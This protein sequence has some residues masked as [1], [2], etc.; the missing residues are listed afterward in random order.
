M[1]PKLPIDSNKRLGVFH[2]ASLLKAS[3]V[4]IVAMI[5]WLGI[6]SWYEQRLIKDTRQQITS[7][8]I[9][10]GN[11]LTTALNERLAL[12]SGLEA[13]VQTTMADNEGLRTD[14]TTFASGLQSGTKGIRAIQLFPPQGPV[15]VY[16]VRSN[17][18]T[19]SRTLQ[20]LINDERPEVRTDVKKAMATRRISLSGPYQLRQ[21]GLG[22]VARL[23]VYQRETFWGMAVIVFDVP[24]ILQLAGMIPP[25]GDLDLGLRDE[26]KRVFAGA[27]GVFH[28]DPV[29]YE[30]TLPGRTWEL[31]AIA[32]Q[33]WRHAY[34]PGLRFFQIAGL[35]IVILLT[36]L[37]YALSNQQ[38]RLRYLVTLRTRALRESEE[39]FRAIFEQAPFGVALMDSQTGHFRLVNQ[40]FADIVG[41]SREE[42]TSLDRTAITAPDDLQALQKK[43]AL[44]SHDEE[45]GF[46]M[47]K[48]LIRPD[49]SHV[50]VDMTIARITVSDTA[51]ARHLTM[52]QDISERKRTEA[53]QEHLRAQLAQAQKMESVG[54]LAGGVA[55]D[56]NNMLGII[57]GHADLKLSTMEPNHPLFSTLHSIRD[58]AQRS[59]NLVR[60]LL[61]FA[62]KQTIMPKILD[63]NI[64]VESM[65]NML[66]R[67]IS[68]DTELVWL[69]GAA[70]WKVRM[71]PI[72]IDQI[73]ANLIV[74]ARDAIDGMG[75]ITIETSNASLDEPL[76]AKNTGAVCGDYV[77]LSVRDNGS[78]MDKQTQE[79]LF[80]PFFTTKET[81]KGTGLGMATVYG[82]VTQNKGCITVHSEPGKG[83]TI[84][85]YL[86][87]LRP[88]ISDKDNKKK[89]TPSPVIPGHE[90]I[91]LA[92]D[93]P[94][95]RTMATE[96]LEQQGYTVLVAH[97]PD[98]AI[99]LAAHNEDHLRLLLTDVIMPG[100]NGRD[101][102][103]TLRASYP[104]IKCLFMSGYTANVIARHGVLEENMSFIQ[105][106]FSYKELGA[107]IREIIDTPESPQPP[108][109]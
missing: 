41:R 75:K 88:E 61:A 86:P 67:L 54:R 91:L 57:L 87:R 36:L 12:L 1:H 83:T 40:H 48:K 16:P 27:P 90:T 20:N 106:P 45:R 56:F 10:Y 26:K 29:T 22:L 3:C 99:Q 85:I 21:G 108:A 98:E 52:I 2:A 71:D 60:Q 89:L 13:F 72:Q 24:P 4:L 46:S 23:A 59:A 49:G 18:A 82:I 73:L 62:R 25:P 17:E 66:R 79:N 77:L 69:P 95:L 19:Q 94:L 15:L 80:E 31:A 97:S 63:I 55:H 6:I 58:A 93:E 105:K 96:M 101:L 11:S 100:M 102:A 30:V 70:L 14:F 44:F 32:P 47:E 109:E 5:L 28:A 74:N 42:M 76:C 81:G 34:L 51:K 37:A 103:D 107:K 50:W 39:R 65:L 84:N 43:I 33:S 8:L 78:G 35:L 104:N 38:D 7:S 64:T 68:E 92:E 53:E 9:P